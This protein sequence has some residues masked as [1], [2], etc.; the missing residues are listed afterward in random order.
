MNLKP[1][2]GGGFSSK[3]HQQKASKA[4][5]DA[6]H[7]LRKND[8]EFRQRFSQ[9]VKCGLDGNGHKFTG[10]EF[11]GKHHSE[12]TKRKIGISNSKYQQGEK[13]SQYGTCWITNGITN[14]KIN[15]TDSLPVGCQYGRINVR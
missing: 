8:I 10:H 13:N 3:E 2:G 11:K 9:S 7:H 15:K 14:K 6:L 12:E 4:G 5:N 1:G